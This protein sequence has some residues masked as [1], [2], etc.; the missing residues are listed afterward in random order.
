MSCKLI[1]PL[2]FI[3]SLK[4]AIA[5]SSLLALVVIVVVVVLVVEW[6]MDNRQWMN[7]WEFK[8]V[9]KDEKGG[10]RDRVKDYFG[11]WS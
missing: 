3:Y 4:F 7:L 5:L 2:N 11:G 1:L 10:P 6:W 9:R 8:K